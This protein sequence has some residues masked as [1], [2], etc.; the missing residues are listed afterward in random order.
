MSLKD[1][2]KD[3]MN[4]QLDEWDAD[5]AK[6][7]AKADKSEADAKIDHYKEINGWE[8]HRDNARAKL[9]DLDNAAEDTWEDVK[10]GVENAWNDVR[11][12]FT[13]LTNRFN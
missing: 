4:A 13:K 11:H 5:V 8:A 12:G 3:K 10:N 2:Y 6:M 7:R 9:K 1:A